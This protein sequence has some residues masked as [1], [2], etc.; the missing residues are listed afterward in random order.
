M[1]Q[2]YLQ[3][4]NLYRA[5]FASAANTQTNL[6]TANLAESDLRQAN[7]QNANLKN[8]C[9]VNTNLEAA[10]FENAYLVGADFRGARYLTA[11]QIRQAPTSYERALFDEA[12]AI[13][14]GVPYNNAPPAEG[15]RVSPR[16]RRWWYP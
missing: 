7:F 1:Y 15:C 8:A 16:P 13:E 12:L 14:L 10:N 6:D 11:E 5:N 9:L 4:A 3:G 2:A